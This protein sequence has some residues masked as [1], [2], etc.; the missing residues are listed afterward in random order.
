M[1]TRKK[2]FWTISSHRPFPMFVPLR[3]KR[4]QKICPHHIRIQ[5]MHTYI[6]THRRTSHSTKR[7][8]TQRKQTPGKREKKNQNDST[9]PHSKTRE[10]TS[11]K[12]QPRDLRVHLDLRQGQDLAQTGNDETFATRPR[13]PSFRNVT[14]GRFVCLTPSLFILLLN[15]LQI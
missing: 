1:Q 5:C 7:K 4:V 6:P 10:Q 11:K 2:N 14:V 9:L 15:S 8:T 3:V 12:E 13:S